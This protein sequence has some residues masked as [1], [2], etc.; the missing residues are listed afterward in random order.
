MCTL[1]EGLSTFIT[2][3]GVLALV[4]GLMFGEG[5]AADERLPAVPTFIRPHL[6]VGVLVANELCAFAEGFSTLVTPKGLHSGVN[7]LMLRQIL[8]AAEGFLAFVTLKVLLANPGR[9]SP[10]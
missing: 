10:F 4:G 7:P 5:G 6:R 2:C 3:Q 9:F 1:A 8:A